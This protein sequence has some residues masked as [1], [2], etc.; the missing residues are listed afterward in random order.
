MHCQP[1][2]PAL[3]PGCPANC[4]HSTGSRDQGRFH[5]EA[6][7]PPPPGPPPTRTRKALRLTLSEGRGARRRRGAQCR[8]PQP[9]LMSA[10]PTP[11][12]ASLPS[13]AKGGVA[14]SIPVRRIGAER[15]RC[16]PQIQ[17]VCNARRLRLRAVG[18]V[19]AEREANNARAPPL[20]TTVELAEGGGKA[21]DTRRAEWQVEQ[22]LG[23]R[24]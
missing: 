1:D 21:A 6:F 9:L 3:A 22:R 23:D 5:S 4:L 7:A 2:A 14:H 15:T 16:R 13:N 11:M 17:T 10:Q 24:R 12:P 18:G 20:Q 19:A 8:W